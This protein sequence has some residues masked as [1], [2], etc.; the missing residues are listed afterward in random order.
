MYIKP[1]FLLHEAS[2]PRV[3]KIC[4]IITDLHKTQMTQLSD[5]GCIKS[6]ICVKKL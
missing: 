1:L 4:K 3:S 6:G 2:F 5:F